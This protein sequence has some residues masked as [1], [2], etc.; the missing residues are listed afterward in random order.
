MIIGRRTKG[1]ENE[2]E[3]IILHSKKKKKKKKNNESR[4]NSNLS[5]KVKSSFAYFKHPKT[6]VNYGIPEV[7]RE[8]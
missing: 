3:E 2:K 5:R 7:L 6:E 4:N 1:K 8:R